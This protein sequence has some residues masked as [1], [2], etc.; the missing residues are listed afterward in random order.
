MCVCVCVCVCVRA[1]VRAYVCVCMCVC[2]R[3]CV[4]RVFVFLSTKR[5]MVALLVLRLSVFCVLSY[6]FQDILYTYNT[7]LDT[8]RVELIKPSC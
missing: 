2:V 6:F 3:V 4:V 8:R 7:Q 1:C 5:E